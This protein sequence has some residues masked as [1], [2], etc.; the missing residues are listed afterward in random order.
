MK[1]YINQNQER[2]LDELSKFLAFKSISADSAFK[3]ECLECADYLVEFFNSIDMDTQLIPTKG[4]PV[5]YAEK[6]IDENFPT[7]LIYGHY[8]VQPAFKEDGWDSDP[9][10]MVIKNK[11][12][13]ARGAADDKGQVFMHMKV[14]E[15]MSQNNS[16][17]LNIKVFLE[18]EEEV[19]S[20]NLEDFILENKSLL[21]SDFIL[22]S[23]TSIISNSQPSITAGVRGMTAMELTVKGPKVDV[24]SGV[25]G[26]I[27]DNPINVLSHIIAKVKDSDGRILIPGFYDDVIEYNESQRA[28]FQE[29]FSKMPSKDDLCSEFGLNDLLAEPGFSPYEGGSIRPTFDVVG[30]TG[31]YQGEGMKTIIPNQ[32]SAKFTFRL[33]ANQDPKKVQKQIVDYINSIAPK[34]LTLEFDFSENSGAAYA[35]NLDSVYYKVAAKAMEDSFGTKCLPVMCGGSIPVASM[36]KKHLNKET[37]F[38]GFGLEEDNIHSPN[39][40]YGIFN[41]NIGI[42]T[43]FNYLNSIASQSN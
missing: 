4:I 20:T 25:Y 42:E 17:P 5:V 30:I 16:W 19:G 23:D 39:E 3:S 34:T 26:G 36:L 14:L 40:S 29:V 7:V 13:Y 33:V 32:A 37:I 28:E 43:I 27:M 9:F 6:I 35:T 2:F 22:I 15:F 31:G 12:I 38:L 11:K 21:E 24:H 8:D 18:G 10:D 1:N 41:M